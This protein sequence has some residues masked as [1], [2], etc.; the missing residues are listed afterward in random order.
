M[1]SMLIDE[2]RWATSILRVIV[3]GLAISC[4]VL[5]ADTARAQDLDHEGEAEHLHRNEFLFIFAGT[6]EAA[7]AHN[8]FTLGVEYERMITERIGVVGTLEYLPSEDAWVVVFPVAVGIVGGL[9][10]FG[11]PGMEIL[12]RRDSAAE[13]GTQDSSSGGGAE[14]L[15]LVRIGAAYIF[16]LGGR[17]SLVPNVSIDLVSEEHGWT[18]AVVYGVS[19]AIGF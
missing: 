5:A 7:K 13:H 8:I 14:N 12:S 9:K 3:L 4:S 11:G 1:E 18:H 16:D 10:V 17:L 15:F 6:Y 2:P 19:F